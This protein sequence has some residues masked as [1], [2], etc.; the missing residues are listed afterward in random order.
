MR[1]L[2]RGLEGETVFTVAQGRPNKIVRTTE[3]RVLVETEDGDQNWA[4]LEELQQ[5]ASGIYAGEEVVL[6]ARGR[7]AFHAAVLATLDELDYALSPRRFWLKDP[8]ERF[9]REYDELLLREEDPTTAREGR[10]LYRR[11][12]VRERSPILRRLKIEAALRESGHLACEACGFDFA[13]QYGGL[14]EGFIECHHRV[15]LAEG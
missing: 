9:D 11:H 10:V 6:E 12:R 14:G 2:V 1:K 7:S 4:S 13:A 8:P 3:D 15:Q 5:L